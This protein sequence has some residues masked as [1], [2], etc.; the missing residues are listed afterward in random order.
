MNRFLS[1][2]LKGRS[3]QEFIRFGIV[4]IIATIIHYSIYYLLLPIFNPT[5]AFTFGY[6]ISFIANLLLTTFFTFKVRFSV[7]RSIGFI[8]SHLTNYFLQIVLLNFFLYMGICSEYAPIPTLFIAIPIN[9]F[10]VRFVFKSL[11]DEK[12]IYTNTGI[13]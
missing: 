9:F 4:G 2:L 12:D 5:I 3:F 1:N 8:G 7:K 13:Q 6:I 11:K 10:L